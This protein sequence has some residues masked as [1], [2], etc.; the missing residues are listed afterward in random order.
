MKWF[1]TLISQSQEQGLYYFPID[2][3]DVLMEDVIDSSTTEN[4]DHTWLFGFL[5]SD[6]FKCLTYDVFCSDSLNPLDYLAPFDVT[7]VLGPIEEHSYPFEIGE[8]FSRKKLKLETKIVVKSGVENTG[9][10]DFTVKEG[11]S[12]TD[13]DSHQ[14]SVPEEQSVLLPIT[15][16]Q[17]HYRR[18]KRTL[19]YE[20]HMSS[21]ST[22][23]QNTSLNEGLSTTQIEEYDAGPLTEHHVLRNP[24]P[25][26]LL[27]PSSEESL[28]KDYCQE[29]KPKQR[30]DEY[31][32][33]KDMLFEFSDTNLES[34]LNNDVNPCHKRDR[35]MN[36]KVQWKKMTPELFHEIYQWEK[37]QSRVK[38]CQIQTKFH[39]NRSTYYRWKKKYLINH[40][41]ESDLFSTPTSE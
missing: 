23:A 21:F 32:N 14:V 10:S 26:G 5:P 3:K 31:P 20:K 24:K 25:D 28:N 27:L 7:S 40:P 17:P 33:V 1:T 39:V 30:N 8:I 12:S 41:E 18:H 36:R 4:T 2:P 9:K 11:N 16:Y 6:T 34:R 35:S 29:H 22:V 19:V 13:I 38:Q 15:H 37:T